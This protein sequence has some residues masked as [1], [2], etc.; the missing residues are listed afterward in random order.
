[1]IGILLLLLSIIFYIKSKK[2]WSF[3]IFISF[4]GNGF[5]LLTDS[6]LGIKNQDAALIYFIVIFIYSLF[7]FDSLSFSTLKS[8]ES[9][10]NLLHN[11]L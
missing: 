5:Y 8:A 4:C 6:V 2:K 7:T 11:S 1:M 3:L 10:K 9:A